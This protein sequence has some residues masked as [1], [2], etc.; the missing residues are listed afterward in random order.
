MLMPWPV[1]AIDSTETTPLLTEIMTATDVSASAEFIELYNPADTIYSLSGHV[2]QYKSAT[3]E[4]WITKLEFEDE[5]AIEPRGYQLS[6]TDEFMPEDHDFSTFNAGLAKSAGHVRLAKIVEVEE[7]D[8]IT[9]EA[10]LVEQYETLD[11][12]GYGDNADSPEFAPAPAPAASKSLKRTVTEDGDYID[13]QNNA[14]DFVVADSP[15]PQHT[16]PIVATEQ[17]ESEAEDEAENENPIKEEP[18]V[19]YLKLQISELFIDPKSPLTDANDEFVELYN[20]NNSS[21]DLTGYKVQTG[22]SLQ[23]SHTF[24]SGLIAAKSYK[25]FKSSS[26]GLTLANSGGRAQ[27][28]A[29]DSS[30]AA[31]LVAYEKADSGSSWARF[32]DGFEWTSSV[33]PSAENQRSPME[34]EVLPATSSRNPSVASDKNRTYAKILITEALPDP[35]KPALDK[36]DEFVELFNPNSFPVSLAGYKVKTGKSLSTNQTLENLII[37]PKQYIALFSAEHRMTLGNNGGQVQLQD[38]GGTILSSAEPYGDA[39][40]GASWALIDN[41]WQ[42]TS[43]P[44]P[45]AKNLAAG[46]DSSKATKNGGLVSANSG[47]QPDVLS[48]LAQPAAIPVRPTDFKLIGGAIVFALLYGLYEFRHE[49]LNRLNQSRSYLRARFGARS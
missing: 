7:I 24:E 22:S 18:T 35:A 28:L 20:P 8:P 17:D 33:T 6:V 26:T 1:L 11:L 47:I 41:E 9:S 19:T 42:W 3:G 25:A 4:N 49:I 46:V 16:L 13:T 38:P 40:E 45:A 32:D 14:E 12:L 44:T 21:V 39:P 36:T 29:P 23:Y 34:V 27:V 2:L 31:D 48:N 5:A 30:V 43:S 10:T 37:Q 15:H